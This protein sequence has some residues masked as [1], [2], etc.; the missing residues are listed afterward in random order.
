[1][2]RI[3]RAVGALVATSL[4]AAGLAVGATPPMASAAPAG[5]ATSTTQARLDLPVLSGTGAVGQP[6]SVLVAGLATVL[7]VQ[8]L[9]DGVPIPGATG[10]TYVPTIADVGHRISALVTIP[11]VGDL[12]TS[13]ITVLGASDPGG[14]RLSPTSDVAVTGSR[15][16]GTTLGVTGPTW[17]ED[18]VTNTYQWLRDGAPIAGATGATYLL[19][20]AD[21]EHS[22]AVEV[23]G[24]KDGFGDGTIT[25]EP[26]ATV[27]G[28][29]LRFTMKPRVTGTPEVGRLL[30][31][32]P[33]QWSGGTE[34]SG[35]PT[36]AYQWLR[37]GTAIPGAVA[38]TYEVDHADAGR[39]LTVLVTATRPAY[40]AGRF[41]TAAVTVARLESTLTATLPQRTVQ[42]GRA[43]AIALV[44]EV[45]GVAAPTGTVQV[46][47]G[48]TMVRKA[49]FTPSRQGRLTVRLGRLA[50]GVHRLVAVYAGTASVEGTKSTLLRLTVKKPPR[51][52]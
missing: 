5:P 38:Q 52:K 33:G 45:A 48:R 26:V 2:P 8:W 29:A 4:V 19:V 18:G 9:R 13:A 27:V 1:M 42:H 39:A 51:K 16:I 14:T 34:A 30:T 6:L 36:Y 47:D 11:V 7:P 31:A 21:F 3:P 15:K 46:Y 35:Q 49:T 28:D 22:V 41:T 10:A 50:P 32:D 43:A 44:L 12:A 25:S 37:D 40:K 23:T 24:R 20:P 17:D